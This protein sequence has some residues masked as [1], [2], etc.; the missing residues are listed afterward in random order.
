M[1]VSI[2]TFKPNGCF[3]YGV[4]IFS[5]IHIVLREIVIIHLL[6]FLFLLCTIVAVAKP[7]FICAFETIRDARTG[8]KFA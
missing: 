4:L 6:L 5:L 1:I 2:K 3:I 7:T 8:G